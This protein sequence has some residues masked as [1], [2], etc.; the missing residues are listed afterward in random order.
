[1][2]DDDQTSQARADIIVKAI[3]SFRYPN[4]EM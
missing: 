1:M 3:I 4:N 2:V